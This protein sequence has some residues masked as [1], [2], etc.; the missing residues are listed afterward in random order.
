[1]RRVKQ[2]FELYSIFGL[3]GWSR[4]GAPEH[5]RLEPDQPKGARHD[6]ARRQRHTEVP[7]VA[8]GSRR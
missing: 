8:P 5:R 1:M 7:F 3:F 4:H 6:A 2:G